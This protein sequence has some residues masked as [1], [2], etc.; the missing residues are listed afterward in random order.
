VEYNK[1][2]LFGHICPYCGEKTKYIDSSYVYGKSYGMIYICK[3][4]D[5]YVGVH[6]GTHKAFGRLANK[7]LREFKKKAH[8]IFDKISKTNKINEIWNPKIPKM[9]N[10]AKSY[11]WLSQKLH[12]KPKYCHI[13]MMDV[14]D[15]K[16]VIELCKN[17]F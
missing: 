8:N 12:I 14:N 1:K 7:E 16:R 9:N 5:A 13:G 2:T 10:R 4:C 11:L 15:C 17:I 6:N 3:D